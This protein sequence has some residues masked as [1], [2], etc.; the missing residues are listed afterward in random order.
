MKKTLSILFVILMG[1]CL[2]SPA[3]A[4]TIT[5]GSM[6]D[7]QGVLTTTQG[8]ASIWD[9]NNRNFNSRPAIFNSIV[10]DTA[11]IVS[12]SLINKYAAPFVVATN[13]T[14]QTPYLTVPEMSDPDNSGYITVGLSTSA[15]Y[16]GLFWGSVDTYNS[17]SFLNGTTLVASFTGT[18]VISPNAAN[19][20]QTAPATNTYVNF[21]DLPTFDSFKLSSTQFAFEVDNIA[22][23]T[24]PVP[25]PATMFLLGTGLV[26]LAGFG[27]KRLIK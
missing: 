12:G 20:N 10:K 2:F 4:T 21:F 5:Y 1:I 11:A 9:F 22:V 19:G 18:D 27:R 14:D 3:H 13:S 26:G 15:N 6:L 7:A 25:E 8:Y 23:G 16:L 24:T 17:I